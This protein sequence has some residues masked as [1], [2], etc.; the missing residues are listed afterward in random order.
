M[1]ETIKN[2]LEL[3]RTYLRRNNKMK[4]FFLMV[5]LALMIRY[6]KLMV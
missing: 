6:K 5:F 2:D 4:V 3:D 1:S